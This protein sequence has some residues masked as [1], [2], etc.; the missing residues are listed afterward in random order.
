M[1]FR[2]GAAIGVAATFPLVGLCALIFRF[3]VPFAGY[4]SGPAA[5]FPALM[6][7]LFYGVLFGGFIVQVVLGGVGGLLAAR[8]GAPDNRKTLK[9]CL[10]FS[11]IGPSMGV[12]TLAILDK[13]IG[14]W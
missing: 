14:P 10:L 12:V 2:K 3:P 6:G 4:L 11:S 5:V 9:L 8:F 7:L 13:I 1:W